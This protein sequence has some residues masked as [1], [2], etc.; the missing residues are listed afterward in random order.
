MGV[1]IYGTNSHY[2]F[3]DRTLAHLRAAVGNKLRR[4]E[5]F[6]LEWTKEP[7]DGGGRVS[8]WIASSVPLQFQ[9]AQAEPRINHDWVNALLDTSYTPGGMILVPEP[10]T[11][12]TAQAERK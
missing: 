5:S 7:A 9:F 8:L 4:Q 11:S 3:D 12:G 10:A 1:L 6:Y 2:D